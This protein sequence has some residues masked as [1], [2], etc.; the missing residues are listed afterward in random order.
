MMALRRLI[1][2]LLIAAALGGTSLS[3][4]LAQPVI[5]V[6]DG[7]H[8]LESHGGARYR[9]AE[10][11]Q[12]WPARTGT[13]IPHGS[14]ITTGSSGFLIVARHGA[15]MT[16]RPNSR[17]ELPGGAIGD[18]VRQETGDLRYRITRAPDRHFAVET[19]Y[20]SLLVK[21]TVFE[22]A[23][24]DH[25]TQ[26][27]VAQGRVQVDNPSGQVVEITSGQ[28]A[29][30]SK[31]AGAGLEV[32]TTSG[33]QFAAAP[34]S[35]SSIAATYTNDDR[36]NTPNRRPATVG[37]ETNQSDQASPGRGSSAPRGGSPAAGSAAARGGEVSAGGADPAERGVPANRHRS[38]ADGGGRSGIEIGVSQ[39]GV[40]VDSSRTQVVELTPGQNTPIASSPGADL[41]FG[42]APEDSFAEA[43]PPAEAAAAAHSGDDDGP[44]T[45]SRQGDV[46]GDAADR[47]EQ[48]SSGGGRSGDAVA[49]AVLVAIAATLWWRLRRS[50]HQQSSAPGAARR[51]PWQRHVEPSRGSAG[52]TIP[53]TSSVSAV[54]DG[55]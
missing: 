11:R 22:V 16:V 51:W 10:D 53:S 9:P 3:V 38:A 41:E 36:R 47:N 31:V 26:V 48:A 18:R 6:A 46:A 13:R 23:V 2:A 17:V 45:G 43:L 28:S 5:A 44:G 52:S 35:G 19:P 12:W 1:S 14:I 15:S 8:V 37:Q 20:L 7:W 25:G 55:S 40:S 24:G 54:H 39:A 27:D 42:A 34:P 32:R 4:A 33:G 50:R 30:I 29:R 49:W 21:G